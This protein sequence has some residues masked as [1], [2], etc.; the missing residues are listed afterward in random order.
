MKGSSPRYS[1]LGLCLLG[2]GSGLDSG[3]AIY[4]GCTGC[5]G[6]D[7]D[8]AERDGDD[9]DACSGFS[10]DPVLPALDLD[11]VT[12]GVTCKCVRPSSKS[13]R[14][15]LPAIRLLGAADHVPYFPAA[16]APT[17]PTGLL[18]VRKEE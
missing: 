4:E 9:V 18:S 15:E 12:D 13:A 10:V 3:G 14:A 17:N 6:G 5:G 7:A 16:P 2:P 11:L 8:G 1:S